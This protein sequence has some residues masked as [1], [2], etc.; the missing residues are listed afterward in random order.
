ME[1]TISQ[2]AAADRLNLS[3]REAEVCALH[4][5]DGRSQELIAEWL[6]LSPRGVR[7]CLARAVAKQ[8]GLRSLRKRIKRPRVVQ[9]SQL[10]SPRGR[11]RGAFNV[12]E[13]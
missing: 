1:T 2:P 7:L 8:P 5:L 6:N 13:I 11:D 12:D 3:P 9:L 10:T 4:F